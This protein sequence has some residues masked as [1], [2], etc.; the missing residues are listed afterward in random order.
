MFLSI[1]TLNYKKAHL[2]TRC[3]ESLHTQFADELAKG[4]IE[5]IIV[6]NDSQDDSVKTIEKEIKEKKYKHI[7]LIANDKNA[8]F[9]AGCNVGAARAK[10]KY[11]LFLNNDTVAKDRSIWE[12]AAYLDKH[13]EITIIGGQLR[14]PDG[15]LQHSVGTFYTPVQAT[16]LLLGLQRLGVVD[17]NPKDIQKVDWVKG[18]LLMIRNDA[19]KKLGG[20]DENIFMYVEDMELC[21]RAQL[22]GYKIY[23][24][25]F[26]N[27]YHE[28]QGS[29]NRTFA[30][31]QIYKSLLYFYKKHRPYS[32]YL[33]LKLI[34]RSKARMLILLGKITGNTYLI[35][36]YEKAL[37][38]A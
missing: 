15:S 11:I 1:V 17:K 34:L 13:E 38:V 35:Q 23:F 25:P 14:N 28:E 19:F 7:D 24:Y 3:I 27:V 18:A 6:D 33:F 8:G 22:V 30:I 32:E 9:G 21:Y 20:F 4:E 12:M 37:T 26:T 2:T 36:T 29:S 10:G 5:V 31:I 16:F